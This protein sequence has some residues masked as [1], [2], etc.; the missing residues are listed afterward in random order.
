MITVSDFVGA[1]LHGLT[2]SRTMS[3]QTSLKVAEAY[4][5]NE[6]LRGFPVPRMT[7][8]QVEI[9]VNFSVG[10]TT[11][12]ETLLK[13]PEICKNITHQ[14]R[15]LFTELPN[16]ATFK[17]QFSQSVVLDREW[18]QGVGELVASIQRILTENIPDK[19]TLTYTLSL[20]IENF[21]YQMHHSK[22]GRGLLAGI[23]NMF[24]KSGSDSSA[25][26]QSATSIRDWAAQQ[27][28]AILDSAIPGGIGRIGDLPELNIFV[29]AA[30]LEGQH[31][32]KMHTAK[33]SFTSE[34]R[35]WVATVKNGEKSYMLDRN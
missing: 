14:F 4:L 17:S 29:G 3:D 22:P 1:L 31:P 7:L 24:T 5:N 10:P 35:K 32:E 25:T 18:E 30:E 16:S 11:S 9:E 34:D 27:V 6:Y 12:L 20:A 21:F 33:F 26:R 8:K 19:D 13:E 28:A 2:T 23:R 15:E